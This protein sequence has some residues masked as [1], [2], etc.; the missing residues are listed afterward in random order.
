MPNMKKLVNTSFELLNEDIF[1]CISETH[2]LGNNNICTGKQVCTIAL[3]EH[4][5]I[6][7]NLFSF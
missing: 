2:R 6:E 7:V 5:C 3:K 1:H 4:I